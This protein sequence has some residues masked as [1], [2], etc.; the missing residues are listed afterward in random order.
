MDAKM[1]DVCKT[2][3]FFTHK[4]R[5]LTILYVTVLHI[6]WAF[7]LIIDSSSIHVTAFMAVRWICGSNYFWAWVLLASSVLAFKSRDDHGTKGVIMLIPQ[8]SIL[9]MCALSAVYCIVQ[10]SYADG[11]IRPR[12]FIFTDQIRL[13]LLAFFHTFAIVQTHSNDFI[14]RLIHDRL[15]VKHGA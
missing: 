14:K 11:V 8:Q 3:S 15:G 5:S 10:S 7:G 1:M 6:I 2:C 4:M 13:V 12:A 9:I